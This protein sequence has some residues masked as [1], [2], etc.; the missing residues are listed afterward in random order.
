VAFPAISCGV[1]G[2][3]IPAAAAIAVST[4]RRFL[5]E[6]VPPEQVLL[7]CFGSEVVDACR[8]ALAEPPS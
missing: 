2:Y 1:Y 3:P 8:K 5:R 6:G 7:C 4:I